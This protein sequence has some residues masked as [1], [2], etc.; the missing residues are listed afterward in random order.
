MEN[1]L[2]YL[3]LFLAVVLV[4]LMAGWLN[5]KRE[6]MSERRL[7][8][9]ILVSGLILAI[10]G[11]FG[12]IDLHFIPYYYLLV[13]VLS[14]LLG[15]VFLRRMIIDMGPAFATQATFGVLTTLAIVGLGAVLFSLVFNY[16]SIIPYG[17]WAS[18]SLLPFLIPVLFAH[19]FAALVKIPNEI[20]K[21]WYYPR[22]AEEVKLDASDYYRLMLLEVQIY[23]NPH[24][25]EPPIKVKARTAGDIPFGLWFQKFVDD[26][27]YKFPNDPIQ[28]FDDTAHEYGWLFYYVKPS[29]FRLRFYID[30]EQTILQNRLRENYLIVAKRVE[31]IS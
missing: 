28:T 31:E 12:R 19:T 7:L 30:F 22:Y 15:I 18:T 9:T 25:K 11:L 26:Y 17:L 6:I 10:S 1:Y 8:V 16:L 29:F 20:F 23:K 13:Q 3:L 27:N 4:A 21:L 5:R 14:L 24:R 2:P